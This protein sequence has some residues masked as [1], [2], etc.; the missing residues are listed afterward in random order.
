MKAP[1]VPTGTPV[2]NALAAQRSCLV[3]L[4]RACVGLPADN[5]IALEHK[6]PSMMKRFATGEANH[7]NGKRV[8]L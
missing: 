5:N 6:V 7:E 1:L 8:K 4:F 3:N 2:V